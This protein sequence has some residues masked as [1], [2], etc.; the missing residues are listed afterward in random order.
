MSDPKKN[1]KKNPENTSVDWAEKLKASMNDGYTE[2]K[3]DT[4]SV[5]DDDLAALLRAQLSMNTTETSLLETLDTSEFE[6]EEAEDENEEEKVFLDPEC[7]VFDDSDDLVEG[8]PDEII[9]D[10]PDENMED[11]L[12]EIIEDDLDE[13]IEDEL[14]ENMEDD[15]DEIIEDD[16]DEIIE[17]EPDENMEDDLD[18]IIEDEPDENMVDD[19]DEIIE[20][21]QDENS[22]E[23]EED[24]FIK[25]E[26]SPSI[27]RYYRRP[28]NTYYTDDRLNGLSPDEILGGA[29][30][31]ALDK[32]N[33]RLLKE[34]DPYYTSG[35]SGIDMAHITPED[36]S[37][38]AVDEIL[39]EENREPIH[40]TAEKHTV[41]RSRSFVQIRDPLQLNLDDISPTAGHNFTIKPKDT[42]ISSTT[43]SRHTAEHAD[44]TESMSYAGGEKE[45]LRDTDLCM[46]LGYEESLRHAD[47]Q[48]RVEQIR[49]N[50]YE[51][52]KTRSSNERPVVKFGRE[53]RGRTDTDRIELLYTRARRYNL[54]RLCL[55]C[56]G[57]LGALLYDTLPVMATS[58]NVISFTNSLLYAPL[59]LLWMLLVCLPFVTRLGR[60][61][62]SLLSF[63]PTRFAVAAMGILITTVHDVIACFVRD[64]AG[65]PLFGGVALVMLSVATLSEYWVTEGEHL[66]FAVVSSG[67]T[68]HVMTNEPTPATT[69]LHHFHEAGKDLGRAN[70]SSK[71]SIFT[72]VHTGQIADYFARTEQYNSYMGRLNYLLPVALLISIVSAGLAVMLKGDPLT[73]GVRTFTA[74]Y[75]SCIPAAYLIA[76]TLPLYEVNRSLCKK[77]AAVIGTAAPDEYVGKYP[78]HLIF[79]DGDALKTLYRKDITLRGDHDSAEWQ[80]IADVIF[81]LLDTPLGV[82]SALRDRS[83]EGYRIDIAETADQYLRLYLFDTE[84]HRTIEVMMGS[85]D[86]L[87]RRGVRLPKINMEQRYKKSEGSRVMYLAFNRSFH[88]AYA[89]EYRVGRTFART[90]TTLFE[91]GHGVS[92]A[93]YDPL[94]DSDMEGINRL[95]KRHQLDVL[96]PTDYEPV[97]K[98]RSSGV[99]ATGRCLDII[100]PLTACHGMKRAYRN[101]YLF[102]WLFL[103]V[104]AGLS[105]LAACLGGQGLLCSVIVSAWQ[106][107][108]ALAMISVSLMSVRKTMDSETKPQFD[109]KFEEPTENAPQ[110]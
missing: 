7:P 82:E 34:E 60:G 66:A 8:D 23:Y 87:T 79:P 58:D 77:G 4:S 92:L 49:A 62:K 103:A 104:S 67:K 53:Y 76:M 26:S 85:H 88:L 102:S 52:Q 16:L 71:R 108:V 35:D 5:D 24:V 94:L 25:A 1:A 12:D 98:T 78:A 69:A 15:L 30:L 38:L 6:E 36:E 20:D 107:I 54:I 46:R 37:G 96:R 51:N 13:I 109:L 2:S 40:R 95:R 101:A 18:E 3:T 19:L 9:E 93:S 47:E 31:Q 50:T 32:E 17:D 41:N 89:A 39:G 33:T 90:A 29:R 27:K 45:M 10:E 63:E 42:T 110:K 21:K 75:L 99:I 86:A 59:G 28:S 70:A 43:A 55:A 65:L 84:N 64:P 91:M 100:R 61:I 22:M 105:M 83:A 106:M 56:T 11:D 73:D 80:R 74:T 81:C 97:R 68:A 14:D 57:A 48:K 44:Y 72:I